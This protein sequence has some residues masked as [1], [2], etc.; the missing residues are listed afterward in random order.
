VTLS[1]AIHS[2]VTQCLALRDYINDPD[3]DNP[4]SPPSYFLN[5]KQPSPGTFKVII[6]GFAA[7]SYTLT[8]QGYATDAS[9]TRP[10]VFA[11]N[12]TV[13]STQTYLVSYSNTPG[14][15]TTA[16][17]LIGDR[18]GDGVVDCADLAIVKASFGKKV[19]QPGYDPRADV[20][21][22]GVVNILDLSAVAGQLPAGT[23]CP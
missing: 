12:T 3:T 21:G 20:N 23:T 13:G 14:S 7:A 1:F 8:I 9:T 19:G 18:N 2:A 10:L 22:D 11:G 17:Y 15:Q 16:S 6:T 4:L 5:V